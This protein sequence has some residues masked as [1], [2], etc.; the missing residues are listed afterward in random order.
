M[1]NRRLAIDGGDKLWPRGLSAFTWVRDADLDGLINLVKSQK[2]SG[3][4]AQ[5]TEDFLGGEWVKRLES[6]ICKK[7]QH[8]YAISFN[9]WTSGLEAIFLSLD[10]PKKSEVIVPTWTMS[11]T[12]SAIRNADLTPVFVDIEKDSFTLD[13][14]KLSN[15]L[16][17]KTRAICSVDL[18]GRPANMKSLRDFCDS[19]DFKLIADSAQCPGARFEGKVPSKWADMG[20]YSLNRHKHFQTGEGGIAVTDDLEFAQRLRALR[21]HGEVAATEVSFSGK[22]IYGHNWRLGEMEAYLAYQ[23]FSRFEEYIEYRRNVGKSIVKGLSEF[24][25]LQFESLPGEIEHDYYILGMRLAADINRDFLKK[26]L[27]CEGLT[28]CVSTYSSLED[29]PGFSSFSYN[30][31]QVAKSLNR[32]EFFGLYLAGHEFSSIDIERIVNVFGDAFRD[33]RCY[34][35]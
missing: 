19:N 1:P 26:I 30:D 7:N 9:S 29:L 21:N 31:L 6:L 8:S 12:I 11:A 28:I 34:I 32:K 22:P 27:E 3:F 35:K 16:T 23:Q 2:L 5:P 24:P 15:L 10:L 4:L 25:Q 33:K 17:S 20:G 14:K 13:T 18:F